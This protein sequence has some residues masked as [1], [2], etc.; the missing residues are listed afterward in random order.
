VPGHHRGGGEAIGDA[1]GELPDAVAAGGITEQ[2][3]FVRMHAPDGDE[4]LDQ[5]VEEPVD[6]RLVPEVPGIGRGT[7]RDHDPFGRRV[8]ADLVLPLLIID[9]GGRAAAAMHRDPQAAL[10]GGSEV[11]LLFQPAQGLASRLQFAGGDFGGPLG[12]EFRLTSV[13]GLA[14]GRRHRGGGMDGDAPG[15]ERTEEKIKQ[16]RGT[17]H[18]VVLSA[19]PRRDEP[20]SCASHEP[21]YQASPR[22]P[23]V[24]H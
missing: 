21:A 9:R 16:P 3:D 14:Q 1:R 22:P 13:G 8:E 12:P 2:V 24:A 17:E 18:K 15:D 23:L 7:G 5:A 20:S 19:E 11:E 10:A 4:I 6:V